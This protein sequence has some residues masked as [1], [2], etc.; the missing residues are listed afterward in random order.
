MALM[1]VMMGAMSLDVLKQM[2]KVVKINQNYYFQIS[3]LTILNA[4]S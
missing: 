1:I 2:V 4:P 3:H